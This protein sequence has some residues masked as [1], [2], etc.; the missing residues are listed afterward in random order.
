MMKIE[1]LPFSKLFQSV[2]KGLTVSF[3]ESILQ[4]KLFPVF[5]NQL[6]PILNIFQFS[7]VALILF[8]NYL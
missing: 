5:V 8:C 4:K 2:L 3:S 7:N 6:L 1:K